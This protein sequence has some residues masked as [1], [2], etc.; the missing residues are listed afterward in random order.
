MRK[1]STSKFSID[2]SIKEHTSLESITFKEH[3]I[4]TTTAQRSEQLT[5][6]MKHMR[7]P[8]LPLYTK[9]IACLLLPSFFHLQA[10]QDACA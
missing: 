3:K 10:T 8:L 2:I 5:N 7:N 4:A 1:N 6:S 9:T